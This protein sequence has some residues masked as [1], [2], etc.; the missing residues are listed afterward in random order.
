MFLDSLSYRS[1]CFG[2]VLWN[3][4]GKPPVFQRFTWKCFDNEGAIQY[5]QREL[6]DTNLEFS[7]C[8]TL[9]QNMQGLFEHHVPAS[10][11]RLP[12]EPPHS[13]DFP[14]RLCC[15]ED[16][17]SQRS[18][19]RELHR[20]RVTWLNG[21]ERQRQMVSFVAGRPCWKAKKLY[22]ITSIEGEGNQRIH[23]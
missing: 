20:E 22:S 1:C 18:L 16:T 10:V 2:G 3:P 4:I 17:A 6:D 8:A 13:N 21:L 15:S 23:D 12:R 14:S 5:L 19:A 11:A 9:L 7:S